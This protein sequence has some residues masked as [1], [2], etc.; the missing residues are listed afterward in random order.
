MLAIYFLLSQ[1]PSQQEEADSYQAPSFT[2]LLPAAVPLSLHETPA[3][4][5]A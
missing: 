3:A 5:Q 1:G 2:P 4:P